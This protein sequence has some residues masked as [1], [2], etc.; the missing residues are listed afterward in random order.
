MQ[1]AGGLEQCRF[2]GHVSR[3]TTGFRP[4]PFIVRRR[5]VP[6]D[7]RLGCRARGTATST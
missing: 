4:L 1:G 5:D 2:L 3:A 6:V 7:A